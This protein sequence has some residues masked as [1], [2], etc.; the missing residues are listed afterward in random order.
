[1]TKQ[2]TLIGP[3]SISELE[4]VVN[5]HGSGQI[6]VLSGR[7]SYQASGAAD[8]IR[9]SVRARRITRFCD[10][11]PNP[12]VEE[13]QL[14]LATYQRLSPDLVIGVGGGS[15]M[16]M[17]KLVRFFGSQRLAPKT[18]LRTTESAS[19]GLPAPPLIAIPTTSGSGSEATH[20][21][22]LYVGQKKVSVAGEFLYPNVAI[23][24]AELTESLPPYQTACT[25]FDALTQAIESY[26]CTQ[27]T[28]ASKADAAEAISLAL[29]CLEQ[30]VSSP[31]PELRAGMAKAANLAGRA[32]NVSRTT[33][34]HA[35]SYP[36]TA[37]FNVPHGQA[38]GLSLSSLLEFNS[39]VDEQTCQD[40]RGT[41]YV[42]QT[43]NELLSLLEVEDMTAAEARLE[44]LLAAIGLENRLGAVGIVSDE[45]IDLI[46]ANGFD[47]DRVKNNPR[48]LTE[49]DLR[50]LLDQIR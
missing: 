43:I 3:G 39:Q 19:P 44:G 38:V 4:Q 7:A 13:L 2:R 15:A 9:R 50:V 25:G 31:T 10:F 47:P 48:R 28:E 26:W 24:D 49:Q 41:D 18:Y 14:A 40:A 27:S 22:T 45:D 29:K 30:A 42:R 5:T 46:V 35:I 36:M 32:I 1:M 8:A 21:A 34:A 20:Y 23:I 12:T 37:H 33:A 6:L 16:D 11:S 17:A